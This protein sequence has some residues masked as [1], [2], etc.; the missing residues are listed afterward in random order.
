MMG[1]GDEKD[2]FLRLLPTVTKPHKREK[3]GVRGKNSRNDQF[4]S[5]TSLSFKEK[6][7]HFKLH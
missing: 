6:L 4:P 5:E 2:D 1:I 7:H 3:Q